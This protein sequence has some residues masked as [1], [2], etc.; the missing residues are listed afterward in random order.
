MDWINIARD[1]AREE[2]RH[3]PR[4]L[5]HVE[6]VGNR[7]QIF[8]AGLSPGQ[9]ELLVAAAWVHDIGYAENLSRTAFHPLDGAR[10]LRG[11]EFPEEVVNL[12][13][14]HSG[15]IFEA[16]ERGLL[17]R[18]LSEFPEPNDQLLRR[19]T[20]IDMSTDPDGNEIEP[21]KRIGEILTRYDAQHPVH[22]A[23]S[24]SGRELVLVSE[25]VRQEL[26]LT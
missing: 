1:A 2:L 11:E 6:S 23:V 21:S 4:R 24:R 26:G 18:L 25:C 5:S 14:Y 8:I 3:L 7:A 10:W 9:A 13:A 20:A 15:A 22:R 19:L 16:E 12:V 17:D